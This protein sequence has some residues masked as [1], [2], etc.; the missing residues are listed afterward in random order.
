MPE[1]FNVNP[2]YVITCEKITCEKGD[3]IHHWIFRYIPGE[4][5]VFAIILYPIFPV[6]NWVGGDFLLAGCGVTIQLHHGS[7]VS[8]SI[9]YKFTKNPEMDAIKI[10]NIITEYTKIGNERVNQAESQKKTEE[11]TKQ[12][13]CDLYNS[14]MEKVKVK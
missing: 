8:K 6:T 4:V 3:N 13:C 5:L 10:K 1:T 2:E 9:E 14:I 7:S 11:K 12:Q